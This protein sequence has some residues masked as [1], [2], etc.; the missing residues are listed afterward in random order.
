ME[1]GEGISSPTVIVT[2][3]KVSSST[4]SLLERVHFQLYWRVKLSQ[5][6]TK[7][8]QKYI[9]VCETKQVYDEN[10]LYHESNGTNLMA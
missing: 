8:V 5:S 9:N 1:N 3:Q 2:S 10:I 4:P 6:L 7:F